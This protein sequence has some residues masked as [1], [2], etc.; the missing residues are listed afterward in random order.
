MLEIWGM[1]STPS[2]P[3]LPASFDQEWSHRALSVGQIEL[4]E[5]ETECKQMTYAKVIY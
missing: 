2:F 1:Q 5:I 3:L 4:F